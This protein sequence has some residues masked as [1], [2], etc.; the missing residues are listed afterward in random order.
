MIYIFTNNGAGNGPYIRTID[1]GF[2]LIQLLKENL[3]EDIAILVPWVYGERQK[4]IIIEEFGMY[5]EANPNLILLDKNL[6][7]QIRKV[8]FDG[9]NYNE[10]MLDLINSYKSVENNIKNHL[11]SEFITENVYGNKVK[12]DGKDVILE[13]SRNPCVATNIKYSYYTSIGYFEKIIK[14]SLKIPELNLNET[15]LKKVLPIARKIES[16]QQLYFQPEPNCFSFEEDTKLFKDNE[17]KTPPLFHPPKKNYKKITEGFY[18]LISGIPNLH[19][20]YK[21]A[22]KIKM[23]IYISEQTKNLENSQRER[24]TIISNENIKFVF[25]RAAWNTIWLSN[26]SKKPLICIEYMD[27]DFPEIY[28]NIISLKKQKLGIIYKEDD[29]INKLIEKSKSLIPGITHFYNKINEK[30]GTLDG[31]SFSCRIIANDF[32]K[33]FS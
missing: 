16:Y 31:I 30:Y 5:L 17:I 12:V 24:P 14:E 3:D 6:G 18:V 25:A 23:K 32:L 20:M 2:E 19:Y 28:F 10:V 4:R 33:K 9:R 13:V 21:F 7:Q 8:L 15:L 11:K 26:I 1:M 22:N 27:G 29:D